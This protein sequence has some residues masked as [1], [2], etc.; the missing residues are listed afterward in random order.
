MVSHDGDRKQRP[1]P[2]GCGL[3]ELLCN[4]G[5][6]FRSEPDWLANQ[7]AHGATPHLLIVGVVGSSRNVMANFRS[8]TISNIAYKATSVTRKPGAVCRPG[9]EPVAIHGAFHRIAASGAC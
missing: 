8:G 5:G 9:K 6:L 7:I 3:P 2:V 1:A 4:D